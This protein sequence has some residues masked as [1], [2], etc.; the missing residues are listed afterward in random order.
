MTEVSKRNNFFTSNLM[1][2]IVGVMFIA[3]S[4]L[5]AM[6]DTSFKLSIVIIQYG[7]ILVP[8]IIVMKV[9]GYSI[10]EK[11]RFKKMNI[12]T[13]VKAFFITLFSLPFAYTLNYLMNIILIKLD[14]FQIQSMDLGTGTAN[15]FVVFFLISITPGICEEVFFRGLMFSGYRDQM[16]ATKAIILTGIL[17]GLFHFNLQNLLLP[18]F[19]GI[20]FAW[21]VYTTD[22]IYSSMLGH[23]LFNGIGVV[24]MYFG[25]ATEV[26]GADLDASI[27]TLGEEGWTILLVMGMISAIFGIFAYLIAKSLKNDFSAMAI[28]DTLIIDTHV[29]VVI[30]VTHGYIIVNDGN[31]DRRITNKKLKS[32]SYQLMKVETIDELIDDAYLDELS[33]K[34]HTDGKSPWNKVF[35]GVVILMYGLLLMMTYF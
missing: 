16:S 10:K 14:L 35:I 7:I 31:E 4:F 34:E 15:F 11:F 32:L 8:I 18:T 22:T 21:L 9:K 17:F 2:M 19:L 12:R 5:M 33:E 23:A 1:F 6:L 29:L 25:P 13:G 20:I 3:G 30:D 27:A 28:G 24:L 26:E